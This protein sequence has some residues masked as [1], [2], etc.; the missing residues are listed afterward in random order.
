MRHFGF[1]LAAAGAALI[2]SGCGGSAEKTLAAGQSVARV[3]DEDVTIHELN[4]ELK[5]APVPPGDQRK[6]MEQAALQQIVDRRI[7]SDIAREQKLDE[8]PDYLLMTKRADET[9]LVQLLQ[10][11][12]A[13]SVKRPTREQA[14]A[15]V[16]ASPNMFDQHKIFLLDQITF[17]MPADPKK[18]MEL[19]PLKSLGD[20]EQWLNENG[21]QYRRLPASLDSIQMP[22]DM[23]QKIMGL[24]SGEVF[25]V[26]TGGAVTASVITA[27]RVEPISGD[28]AIGMATQIL[29]NKAMGEAAQKQLESQLK[30]RRAKVQYQKGY[31]A[32]PT[33]P[34]SAAP[35]P[36]KPTAG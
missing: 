30:E 20:I 23:T 3:G 28:K 33:G 32:L 26:P 11:K 18:L 21:L 4:A 17:Q 15:F 31:S 14:K 27:T 24:P 7:L 9:V 1:L 34:A 5:G 13:G 19:Q 35:A 12:I 22:A 10:Q 29:Q 16:V 36:T 25:V 2:L 6:L 8:T